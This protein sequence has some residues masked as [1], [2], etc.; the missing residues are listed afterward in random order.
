MD[1]GIGPL[2]I[3]VAEMTNT[4]ITA[5]TALDV[6]ERVS[7]WKDRHYVNLAAAR[8][9]RGGADQRTKIWVKGSVLTIERGKGYH[10]S[11]WISEE[12]TLV[13]AVKAAGG[14]VREV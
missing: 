14:T 9:S 2:E 1:G 12:S 7:T 3:G 11:A 13:E 6:V 5:V 4:I 10:S 8:G